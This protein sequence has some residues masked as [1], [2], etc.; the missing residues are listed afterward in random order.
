M[1]LTAN[2]GVGKFDGPQAGVRSVGRDYAVEVQSLFRFLQ[3]AVR[4]EEL[5]FLRHD[6]LV[7]ANDF[8]AFIAQRQGEAK[9]GADAIAIGPNVADDAK[10]ATVANAVE[11]AIDELG[12]GFQSLFQ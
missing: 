11:D 1:T 7:P 8:F 9:L 2:R 10:G 3:D 12:I 5:V 4:I 6:V